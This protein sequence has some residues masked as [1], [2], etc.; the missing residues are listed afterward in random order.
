MTRTRIAAMDLWSARMPIGAG[1]W[2]AAAT[3]G[4]TWPSTDRDKFELD[5]SLS[6]IVGY[7]ATREGRIVEIMCSAEHPEASI[8]LLARA[9]G[10]AIEKDFFRVRLDARS[11]GTVAPTADS[12]RRGISIPRGGP[13]NG[14]HG[15]Y[16]QAAPVPQTDQ[17]RSGPTGQRGR[18][19]PPLPAW[20]CWSTTRSTGCR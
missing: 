3:N 15:E 2:D 18:V 16:L 14:L 7:A 4:F 6:P 12:G 8:Q 20:A 11:R 10:D 19:A 17:P 13:G 1:W 9:C 5:E